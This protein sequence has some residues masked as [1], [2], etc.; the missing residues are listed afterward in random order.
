MLHKFTSAVQQ[1][2]HPI[3]K[4][5]PNPSHGKFFIV[6]TIPM[7]CYDV[8]RN[9]GQGGSVIYDTEVQA[10]DA[11]IAAGATDIQRADCTFAVKAGVA[12]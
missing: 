10:I 9:G 4:G 12:L 2:N 7:A 11:L 8:T 6:G 1:I 5:A 3:H